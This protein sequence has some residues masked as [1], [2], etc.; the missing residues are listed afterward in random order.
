MYDSEQVIHI[1]LSFLWFEVVITWLVLPR[2]AISITLDQ[3]CETTGRLQISNKCQWV[4]LL[5]LDMLVKKRKQK[6]NRTLTFV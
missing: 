2:S 6:T 1:S 5:P 4:L 3:S